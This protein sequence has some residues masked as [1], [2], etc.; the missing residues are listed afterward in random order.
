MKNT[1]IFIFALIVSGNTFAIVADLNLGVVQGG[2][3][4]STDQSISRSINSIGI[5]ANLGK[6]D[7]TSG[8][9]L[10]WYMSGINN[11]DNYSGV[12]NQTLSSSDMGPSFRWQTTS[13]QVFSVTYAYGIISKGSFND[14]TTTEE[15]AGESHLLK[16]AMESNISDR[17]LI[18]LALNYYTAGYKTSL[19]SSVQTGVS[20]KNAWTYPSISLSYRSF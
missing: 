12:L 16:L 5:F 14:G 8:F 1:L 6:S 15:I 7:A 19:V 20:Y 13:R 9:L 17:I 4:R 11:T 10:G 2:F 18:G 3:S